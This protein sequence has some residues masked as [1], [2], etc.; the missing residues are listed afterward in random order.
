MIP[1]PL[2]SLSCPSCD[3]CRVGPPCA[4]EGHPLPASAKTGLSLSLPPESPGAL[5]FLTDPPSAFSQVS[6]PTCPQDRV[7][8]KA[9]TKKEEEEARLITKQFYLFYLTGGPERRE[10]QK[11]GDSDEENK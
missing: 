5:R 4:P 6:N 3:V 10:G 1:H 8:S 7:N 9:S 11:E 2:L